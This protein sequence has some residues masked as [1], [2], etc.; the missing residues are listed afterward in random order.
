MSNGTRKVRITPL[1]GKLPNIALMRLAAWERAQGAE[2]HWIRRARRE[3]GEPIYDAV[4]ASAIF[5]T[6]ARRIHDLLAEFPDALIGGDGADEVLGRQKGKGPKIEDIVPTQF[7]GQ[8]YSAYPSFGP[9]IGYAMRGCRLKCKF[10]G[11]W[12]N[13]GF[14]R[15][16][17]RIEQIW[18]GGDHARDI[19]LLDNDFFGHEEWRARVRE[20]VDGGFRVCINQGINVRAIGDEDAEA[21][22]AMQPWNDAFGRRL[23]YCAWDNLGDERVFFDG[24]E[25]LERAGWPPH[26][27]MAYMLTG[28][29]RGETLEQ[30]QYRHGRMV[31]LGIKPYPMVHPRF[32]DENPDHYRMLRRFQ[33]WAVSPAQKACRFEDFRTDHRAPETSAV[34]ADLFD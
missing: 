13:E 10:C 21:V 25:R 3:L 31:A 20:I 22:V 34:I 29:S 32:R 17:S 15:P 19:H 16:A 4:Y 12:R 1:D 11:V 26:R 23:L 2:V 14:A 18:R 7:V 8:D 30:I 33:S 5:S 28:F 27:V 24:I 6:T 9:S